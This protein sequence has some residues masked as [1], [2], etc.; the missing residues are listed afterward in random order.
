MI[1]RIDHVEIVTRDI[2]KTLG[3]YTQVLSFKVK[4][5]QPGRPGGSFQ[6]IVF[7]TLGDTMLEVIAIPDA[8]PLEEGPASV[9]YRM[10]AL[11]VED[12]E[13]AI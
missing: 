2:E 1:K 13:K 4:L 8:A 7:L 11:Q 9:G 10:M 12:M 5:R 6:E 3:F